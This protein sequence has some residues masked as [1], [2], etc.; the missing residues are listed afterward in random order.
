MA[1]KKGLFSNVFGKKAKKEAEEVK[2][3]AKELVEKQ[4]EELREAKEKLEV[5]EKEK[6]AELKQK[7]DAEKKER[8]EAR[9]ETLKEAREK[10]EAE[11]AAPKLLAQH[12]VEAGETLSHIALKYYKHA[13]P[14]YWQLILEANKEALSG[15]EKNV[16][17]G[18]VIDVPE[19]PEDLKD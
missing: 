4:T 13:T 11:K 12:T 6:K 16:R 7:L 5:L 1:E 9:K 17:T 19:L 3:E 14:P 10:F 15:S 8:L 2:Q 18:M